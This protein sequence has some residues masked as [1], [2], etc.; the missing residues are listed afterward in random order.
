[1]TDRPCDRCGSYEETGPAD[2]VAGAGA[3][4]CVRCWSKAN[5]EQLKHTP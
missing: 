5:A 1:M 4:L 3:W 2:V